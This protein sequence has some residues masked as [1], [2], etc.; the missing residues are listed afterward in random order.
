MGVRP[1]IAAAGLILSATFGLASDEYITPGATPPSAIVVV[2]PESTWYCIQRMHALDKTFTRLFQRPADLEIESVLP[3]QRLFARSTDT[4]TLDAFLAGDLVTIQ[5]NET[6]RKAMADIKRDYQEKWPEQGFTEKDVQDLRNFIRKGDKLILT[7]WQDPNPGFAYVAPILPDSFELG[8]M[9]YKIVLPMS[10]LSISGYC[11][12]SVL[13]HEMTHYC[14]G[15][16]PPEGQMKYSSS[17]GGPDSDLECAELAAMIVESAEKVR[18]GWTGADF[19]R[20]AKSAHLDDQYCGLYGETPYHTGTPNNVV[21][22]LTGD[23]FVSYLRRY[24]PQFTGDTAKDLVV[25][26]NW[27]K[28]FEGVGQVQVGLV[29]RMGSTAQTWLGVNGAPSVYPYAPGPNDIIEDHKYA[30]EPVIDKAALLEK[31]HNIG[32][33]PAATKAAEEFLKRALK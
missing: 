7:K 25:L 11:D 23:L 1:W 18:Q 22:R 5:V 31:V 13:L 29:D 17:F 26:K 19:D 14:Q 24:G 30:D 27:V 15:V 32:A 2:D 4:A 28:R 8:H 33:S 9:V 12:R 10:P 16:Y 3:F 6:I 21:P 20:L